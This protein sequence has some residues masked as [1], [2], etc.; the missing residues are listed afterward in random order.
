[1]KTY[2]KGGIAA[3]FA[4]F[5]YL[6]LDSRNTLGNGR[7]AIFENYYDFRG[8]EVGEI[9][10]GE[11]LEGG[12]EGLAVAF[13]D[14]LLVC[15]IFCTA[16]EGVINKPEEQGNKWK[17]CRTQNK[18]GEAV[19]YAIESEI[20]ANRRNTYGKPSHKCDDHHIDTAAKKRLGNILVE[21][22][23]KL[24]GKYCA[25]LVVAHR[26]EKSVVENDFL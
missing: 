21:S 14:R 22:V 18:I 10:T 17:S 20:R 16:G 12:D 1:M 5:F 3:F 15:L 2:K 4:L 13:I 25:D 23:A 9:L 19:I 11:L 8:G 7:V 6:S 26:V 24:V